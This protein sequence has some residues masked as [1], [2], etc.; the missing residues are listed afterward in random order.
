VCHFCPPKR[1]RQLTKIYHY[2]K[3]ATAIEH[4]LPKMKLRTG[5]LHGMNDPKENQ[6]WAFGG[7]NVNYVVMYPETYSQVNHIDHQYKFGNDI[8]SSCQII[9][10]VKDKPEKGFKNEIMWAHYADNHKGLCLE[11]DAEL[12]IEENKEYLTEYV[13]ESVTYGQHEKPF[14]ASDFEL[15]K[16]QAIQKIVKACYKDL[17]LR[18]S[19]YWEKENEQRLLIF[20]KNQKYLS[21][22]ESLTG[23]YFGLQMDDNY[24]PSVDRFVD[25]KQTHLFNLYYE[26]NKLKVMETDKNDFR[27][28]ITKKFLKGE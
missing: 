27:L 28:I 17:F 1:F 10:F 6:P 25:E 5:S 23:L 15:T 3:L 21:I 13:F 26:K 24:R 18:K 7:R 19:D 22:S 11:L 16:E 2:T 4:I 9:C 20:D 12:F 8:K 14:I